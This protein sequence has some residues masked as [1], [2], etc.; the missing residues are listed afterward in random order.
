MRPECSLCFRGGIPI[1]KNPGLEFLKVPEGTD[2]PAFPDLKVV[3]S[4]W[5]EPFWKCLPNLESATNHA[6]S[7]QSFVVVN[8]IMT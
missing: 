2:I 6:A 1:G 7:S 3:R 4:P 8:A 5:S